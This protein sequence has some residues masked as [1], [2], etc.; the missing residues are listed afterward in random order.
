MTSARTDQGMV[1]GDLVNTAARLQSVAE[2]GHGHRR[3][4]DLP[5]DV[6]RHRL[7]G[8][9]RTIV[10]GQGAPMPSWRAVAI[11]ARLRGEG[12]S[13]TLEP[14]F[15]GRDEELRS[16]KDQFHGVG[17]RGQAPTGHD[18]RTGRHRQEQ[19]CL[20]VRKVPG[21]VRRDDPVARGSVPRLWRGD[22]L[23]GARR[24]GPRPGRDRRVRRRG[25]RPAP[26]SASC[27]TRR[28]RTR[29]APLDPATADG[30]A[31]RRRAAGRV[32]RGAVRGVAHVLRAAGRHLDDD[33]SSSGTCNGPTRAC[34]T[35][36]ST[37]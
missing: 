29:G 30:P 34:S 37:C 4:I 6:G 35:S 23:L 13:A 33:C 25:H 28:S 15:V 27:S 22:Q 9:R 7:R 19:A 5:G 31:R 12:R 20:G 1:V 24:D 21:R 14:P 16:L 18:H 3:R 8:G 32:P 26:A 2:P 17:A 11:T 36:S 10:Q